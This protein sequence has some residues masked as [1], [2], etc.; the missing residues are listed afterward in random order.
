[1]LFKKKKNR[2]LYCHPGL[3]PGSSPLNKKSIFNAHKSP[4]AVGLSTKKEIAKFQK[5]L[6]VQYFLLAQGFALLGRQVNIQVDNVDYYIDL[7]FYHSKLQRYLVV[8]LTA[9]D[10]DPRDVGLI[11]FYLSAV[12]SIIKHADDKPTIGLLLC[13]SKKNLTVEYALRGSA[14]PI[15][16]ASYETKL[17]EKLP[18]KFKSSL[19][20]IKTIEAELKRHETE[21]KKQK[22]MSMRRKG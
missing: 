6:L 2:H 20:T 21:V 16:V 3:D 17:V 13:K 10:F 5:T 14:S 22:K 12:D 19:P 4:T 15:G 1:M 8:E 18:K 9:K 11:N 7:L